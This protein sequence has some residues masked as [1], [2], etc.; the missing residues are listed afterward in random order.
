[1]NE[2]MVT[3]QRVYAVNI[4]SYL[5]HIIVTNFASFSR[6]VRHA[7]GGQWE[8]SYPPHPQGGLILVAFYDMPETGSGPILTPVP[9]GGH[10]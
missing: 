10:A 9:T 5:H 4:T 7:R 6:L 1:M 3:H 2:C 8:Y